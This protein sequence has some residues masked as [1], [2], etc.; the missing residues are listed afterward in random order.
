MC[1]CSYGRHHGTDLW[2]SLVHHAKNIEGKLPVR[3]L[4]KFR[5]ILFIIVKFSKEILPNTDCPAATP[6]LIVSE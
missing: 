6:T 3:Y 2:L 1:K 4:V 5:R